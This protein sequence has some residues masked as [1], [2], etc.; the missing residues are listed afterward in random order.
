MW[1]AA[2]QLPLNYDTAM[3]LGLKLR[4]TPK[5]IEQSGLKETVANA[6]K[7]CM[8]HV[9]AAAAALALYHVKKEDIRALVDQSIRES[10]ILVKI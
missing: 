3:L 8:R 1:Q 2:I 6:E 7:N 4:Y 10:G 9:S 5:E